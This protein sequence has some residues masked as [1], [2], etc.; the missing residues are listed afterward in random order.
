[1]G[2]WLRAAVGTTAGS[3][4]LLGH[5]QRMCSLVSTLLDC[6]RIRWGHVLYAHVHFHPELPPLFTQIFSTLMADQDVL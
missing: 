5:P 2:G 4:L 3:C 1:M 6:Q